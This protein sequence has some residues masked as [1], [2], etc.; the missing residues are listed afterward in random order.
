ME[1][2]RIVALT[3]QK[4]SILSCYDGHGTIMFYDANNTLHTHET[5]KKNGIEI[6]VATFNINIKRT[7]HVAIYKPPTTHIQSFFQL[8]K[9]IYIKT[10]HRCP[11]IH[12]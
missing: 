2:E 6:I 7:I 4:F 9:N 1:F 3:N 11:T 10:L 8:L 5:Y 12:R